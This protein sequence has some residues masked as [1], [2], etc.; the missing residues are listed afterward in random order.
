MSAFFIIGKYFSIDTKAILAAAIPFKLK[1]LTVCA[2]NNGRIV[3]VSAYP[4]A[5]ETAV[6]IAAAVMLAVVYGTFDRSVCKF[7]S[8][9]VFSL[10]KKL[11]GSSVFDGGSVTFMLRF[12]GESMNGK[13]FF[14]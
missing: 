4:Y 1:G 13:C 12:F 8:H 6:I 9:S 11:D 2:G 10:F 14:F 3:F 5:F 7:G